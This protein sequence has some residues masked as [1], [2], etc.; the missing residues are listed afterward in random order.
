MFP[1]QCSGLVRLQGW[2]FFKSKNYTNKH[3]LSYFANFISLQFLLQILAP[4]VE[5]KQ[6]FK[7]SSTF[8]YDVDV[9]TLM[10]H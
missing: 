6:L 3:A 7:C 9:T 8:I 5:A 2:F 4:T 10:Q 1:L